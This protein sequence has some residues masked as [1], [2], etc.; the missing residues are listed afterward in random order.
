MPIHGEWSYQRVGSASVSRWPIRAERDNSK[1]PRLESGEGHEMWV[2]GVSLT[3]A[4][5]FR[6]EYIVTARQVSD[7]YL[8]GLAHHHA[9]RIVSF[10]RHLPWE[11]VQG[12]NRSLG[13]EP[14]RSGIQ[15]I[16]LRS[17]RVPL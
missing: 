5:L 7:A 3:D 9:S 12:A 6:S 11:A 17:L 4:N 13:R 15:L 14:A 10:D 2:D 8:L 1:T 16:R